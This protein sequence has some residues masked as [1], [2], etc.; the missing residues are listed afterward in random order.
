VPA[1]DGIRADHC[2]DEVFGTHRVLGGPEDLDQI[3][4]RKICGGDD[5]GWLNA[6]AP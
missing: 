4:G 5:P 2:P 3:A 1:Q 6:S